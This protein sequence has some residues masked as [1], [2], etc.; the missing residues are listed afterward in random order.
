[1]RRAQLV[2]RAVGEWKSKLIDLTGRNNLLHYRDLR[3]GTL[4]LTTVDPVAI[5]DLLLG[6]TVKLS[7]LFEDAGQL[8]QVQLRARAI[9]NKAKENEEERGLA[10]V[11]IACGLATWA[12]KR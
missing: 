6:K 3:R 2:S 7:S 1:M 11:S 4:D 12:N 5:G 10:T 9:H 8:D